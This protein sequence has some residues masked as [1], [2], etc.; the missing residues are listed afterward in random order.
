METHANHLHH[1]PGKKF[2]HYF[3]EFLMLFLAVFC[4]FLAEN[5]RERNVEHHR[6]KQFIASMLKDLEADTAKLHEVLKDTTRIQGIDSLLNILQLPSIKKMDVRAAYKFTMY[7][8]DFYPIEF[9]RNTL[10]QLKSGGNMRLIRNQNVVDSLNILDNLRTHCDKQLEIHYQIAITAFSIE[11]K[12][13]NVFFYRHPDTSPSFM[14][15]DIQ[16]IHEYAN[17]IAMLQGTYDN[18]QYMLGDYLD[19][20]NRL[21]PFIKK[22][23][24]L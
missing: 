20:C 17:N 24:K 10:T 22:E 13:F 15:S 8:S 6:E 5:L 1:A 18:Y 21:I 23:Y 14:T 9:T 7:V 16:L 4:G 3:F 2:W 19:Y 11:Y 12:I